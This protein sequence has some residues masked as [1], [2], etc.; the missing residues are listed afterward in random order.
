MNHEIENFIRQ[1]CPDFEIESIESLGEGDFCRAFLVNQTGVFRFAKHEAARQSLRRENCL[2]PQIAGRVSL[3]IPEPVRASLEGAAQGAFIAYEFLPDAAL[4]REE[5]LKLDERTRTR[6]AGQ[7]ARFLSELHSFETKIAE[8]CGVL[9]V[10]YAEKYSALLARIRGEYRSLLG[11][12]EFETAEKEIVSFLE[13]A[14]FQPVLLHGDLS[15]DHV[16]YDGDRVTSII[17]FGDVMIG[18]AAWDFL[19]IYEDYGRD[20]FTR[21]V[22]EY[23]VEDKQ[24]FIA[25]VRQLSLIEGIEW[26]LGQ[27][28][29]EN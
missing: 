8:D 12:D 4:T 24:K 27:L 14:N 18:D 10:D 5:Y 9:T 13:A 17:D 1:S 2:L 28:R 7:V 6:C 19:W 26:K 25:R 20:F 29:I 15:P 21:A 16:L 22:S 23:A 3:N 11:K